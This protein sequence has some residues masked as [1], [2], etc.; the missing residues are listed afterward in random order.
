MPT[1]T[2]SVSAQAPSPSPV[3]PTNA[4]AVEPVGFPIDPATRLGVVTGAVGARTV[5]WT[6]GPQALD[7]S[8]DDQPADDPERANRSGWDC[9]V[10][11]E[12]EGIAAVD[13]Y[14][15]ERTPV[16]ATMDGTATLY[17]ITVANTFDYYGISREP[18]LGNPDRSRAPLSPFPGASGGKGVFVRIENAG[19][20][21]EAAHL[22]LPATAGLVPAAAFLAGYSGASD[23]AALFAAMRGYQDA[24]A[25][26]RWP[27]RRGDVI[28]VSG[29]A[30]YSEAPHLHYTVQRKD[31]SA[32]LC[33]TGEAGF[34]DGGW[35][36][37]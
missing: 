33:P 19:F 35:L 7:Y 13:W 27:V 14:I 9:R 5:V 26:A 23:Y 29:D 1:L 34:T 2:P 8:R 4:P 21:T 15:P 25:I 37:K 17:A 20:I 6:G 30:G 16:L 28:G 22:D 12:Y 31:G 32:L 18:Y 24:T 3:A 36:L 10:H 11:V